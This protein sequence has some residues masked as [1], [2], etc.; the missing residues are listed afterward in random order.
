MIVRQKLV[1]SRQNLS[2]LNCLL[3]GFDVICL[4]ALVHY[5]RG[6]DSDLYVL[7]LLPILLSSY[8]SGRRGINAT[9]LF[10]SVSYV[11]MMLLEDTDVLPYVIDPM[12][13][14]GIGDAYVHQL[15]R[16]ILAKSALLVSVSFIWA[17]FCE[18]MS[19]LAQPDGTVLE[20]FGHGGGGEVARRLDVPVLATIPI[21]VALRRGGDDGAP[22]VLSDPNDPAAAAIGQLAEALVG[23]GRGLAGRK[24]GLSVV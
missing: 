7:Y 10:V 3:I 15:W 6:V 24:L 23:L 13:H 8:T 18:Y 9:A 11:A 20:L 12:R 5:T 16:R 2:R 19:G 22:I 17:R 21:S 14:F 4:T 1:V